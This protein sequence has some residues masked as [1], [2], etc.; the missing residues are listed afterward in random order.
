VAV[1]ITKKLRK[2]KTE[3]RGFKTESQG[4]WHVSEWQRDRRL[5]EKKSLPAEGLLI[6]LLTLYV[7][8]WAKSEARGMGH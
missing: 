4:T 6:H 3:E 1:E 7:P 8:S 2:K 5:R